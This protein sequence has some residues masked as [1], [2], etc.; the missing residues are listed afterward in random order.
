MAYITLDP[1]L[2]STGYAVFEG[3]TRWIEA[4]FNAEAPVE[5]GLLQPDN[6]VFKENPLIRACNIGS[7]IFAIA[8]GYG[9][10]KA[11][12]E[13]PILFQ[14]SYGHMAAASGDMQKIAAT[15]G[16]FAGVLW[17]LCETAPVLVRTWK[18][19]LPKKVVEKRIQKILGKEV[20][21]TLDIQKDAWDAVGIGLWV[22][23]KFK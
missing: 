2:H 5:A 9:V 14:S 7:K 10:N 8:S 21:K 17:D 22:Q 1:G 20:C 3:D 6:D 16:C 19:Q 12:V 23:G 18:G 11:F 13:F 15:A 4:G